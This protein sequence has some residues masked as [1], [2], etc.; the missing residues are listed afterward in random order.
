MELLGSTYDPIAFN[1]S[2]LHSFAFLILFFV[3]I[4]DMWSICDFD[5]QCGS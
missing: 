3:Y 4:L 5:Q 1:K 2:T